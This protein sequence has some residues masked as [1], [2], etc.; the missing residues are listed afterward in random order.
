MLA[1]FHWNLCFCLHECSAI[2]DLSISPFVVFRLCSLTLVCKGL[3]VSPM[4]HFPHSH[5]IKEL[6][7]QHS[8][9]MWK[10]IHRHGISVESQSSIPS[11]VRYFNFY[12]GIGCVSFV[13]YSVLCY[14]WWWLFH[15]A[16]HKFRAGSPCVPL[17]SVLVH[18]MLIPLKAPE[19]TSIWIGSPRGV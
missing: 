16:D 5:G 1:L 3:H 19:T 18:S 4:Y 9:W 12:P 8:V 15:C 7:L 13:L 17:S 6:H 2:L 14:L 10:T 11:R